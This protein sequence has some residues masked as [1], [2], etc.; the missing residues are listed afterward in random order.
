MIISLYQNLFVIT[1]KGAEDRRLKNLFSKTY[2]TPR[3]PY[4]GACTT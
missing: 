2:P 3:T 1:E 4:T